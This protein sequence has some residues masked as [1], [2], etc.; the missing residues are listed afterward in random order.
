MGDDRGLQGHHGLPRLERRPHLFRHHQHHAPASCQSVLPHLWRGGAP[1]QTL[2]DCRG[3]HEPGGMTDHAAR[4]DH[5]VLWVRDPVAAADFYE[6]AVGME[7]LRLTEFARGPGAVPLRARQRRDH[8]RPHAADLR[9]TH[10]DA[11]RR[12]RQRRPPRQPR[13]PVHAPR[14]LRRPSRP[15]R[16]TR[17]TG[18]GALV[19]L[20]R[21]PGQG[22]RSFYFR[23]PDGNVFEARHY[24]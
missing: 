19:R 4:L 2:A 3:R 15:P 14:R 5:V 22:D 9:G 10:D 7:P 12:G 21:S 8:P 11:A 23:D 13:L 20:L 16:G 17:R 6:K 1:G 24:D 18:V